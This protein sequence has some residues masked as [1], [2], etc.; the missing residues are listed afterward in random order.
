MVN[1]VSPWVCVHECYLS[2]YFQCI[3][4]ARF[5]SE[6][7]RGFA[8]LYQ[9]HWLTDRNQKQVKLKSNWNINHVQYTQS[10]CSMHVKAVPHNCCWQSPLLQAHY[11]IPRVHA[12]NLGWL[13]GCLFLLV[14]PLAF[15]R[16]IH[17]M[18]YHASVL[19]VAIIF[20]ALLQPACTLF[21]KKFS[22]VHAVPQSGAW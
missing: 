8:C 15:N 22:A 18:L 17:I 3:Y 4:A 20:L 21:D 9:W 16:P 7:S 11:S 14:R 12:R 2:S 10:Y 19:P 5:P 13:P 1:K 6:C